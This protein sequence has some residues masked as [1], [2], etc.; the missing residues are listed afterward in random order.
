MAHFIVNLK[1]DTKNYTVM[2]N[3]DD[4]YDIIINK[5]NINQICLE[6]KNKEITCI[7]NKIITDKDKINKI[8]DYFSIEKYNVDDVYENFTNNIEQ[9]H[10]K[11]LFKNV[12]HKELM[13]IDNTIL[14]GVDLDEYINKTMLRLFMFHMGLTSLDKYSD[15]F[16]KNYDEKIR[17]IKLLK[18]NIINKIYNIDNILSVLLYLN[19]LEY[20]IKSSKKLELFCENKIYKM[21]KIYNEKK[22]DLYDKKITI[23][24]YEN[25]YNTRRIYD[26]DG[27]NFDDIS[28]YD[29]TESFINYQERNMTFK[30][31]I[32]EYENTLLLLKRIINININP[33]FTVSGSLM[34]Y[35]FKIAIDYLK[36]DNNKT[37]FELYY[38]SDINIHD[39][40]DVFGSDI[41]NKELVLKYFADNNFF[42][43][44]EQ[45]SS[46]EKN[47]GYASTITNT[48]VSLKKKKDESINNII[49]NDV[50][51]IGLNDLFNKYIDNEVHDFNG[52]ILKNNHLRNIQNINIGHHLFSEVVFDLSKKDEFFN[53]ILTF[54]FPILMNGIS[55]NFKTK[56]ITV[57]NSRQLFTQYIC[58]K[59]FNMCQCLFNKINIYACIKQNRIEKWFYRFIR[60]GLLEINKKNNPLNYNNIC[61]GYSDL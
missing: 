32:R 29:I 44:V 24:L 46:V 9:V 42:D 11:D 16:E 27:E 6:F 21:K 28:P 3:S 30:K 45:D 41:V 19:P 58:N 20:N 5:H 26:I 36:P 12:E 47:P 57:V 2:T 43:I 53:D 25:T 31:L 59:G 14:N 10:I 52:F 60:L 38:Y 22:I 40:I 8:I 56:K 39:D 4:I 7:N 51:H 34:F 33:C 49:V 37:L 15:T 35:L 17:E 61:V 54:D 48:L 18:Q 13:D 1:Y 55:F 23:C 50:A